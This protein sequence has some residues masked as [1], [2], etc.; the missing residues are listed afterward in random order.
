[1]PLEIER[2]FLVVGEFRNLAFRKSRIRQGYLASGKGATVRIRTKGDNGYITVKGKT[3]EAGI[4]RYEWEKN[5]SLQDAEELL[6]LCT[7]GYIDKFR[8]EIKV[9]Q[10]VFEVDEFLGENEGL[11]IAE[12]ELGS[13]ME[14]YIR[15]SWLGDEVTGIRKYYNSQLVQHPFSKWKEPSM[16]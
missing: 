15:P 5:I 10:H 9:G 8:Y 16:T 3:N 7:E 13:E 6:R 12:V 4:T 2:K 1:M 14:T 11:I